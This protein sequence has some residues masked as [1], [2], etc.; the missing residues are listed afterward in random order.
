VNASGLITSGTML[1]EKPEVVVGFVA[2]LLKAARDIQGEQFKT[3]EHLQMFEKYTQLS[4]DV[5]ASVQPYRF[6]PD[7]DMTAPKRELAALQEI[8]LAAGI[9]KLDQPL[10]IDQVVDETPATEA[11]ER[12][13]RVGE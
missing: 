3:D 13:G 9:L 2:A 12:L 7:F 8:M 1:R 5:L 4:T 10:A 6:D 11:A